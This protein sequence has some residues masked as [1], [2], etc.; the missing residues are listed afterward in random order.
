MRGL[1][2]TLRDLR[3]L[4]PGVHTGS[5]NGERG[6][7]TARAVQREKLPHNALALETADLYRRK[8]CPKFGGGVNDVAVKGWLS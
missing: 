7:E 6:E 3:S 2:R 1:K 8:G 4:F 5:D